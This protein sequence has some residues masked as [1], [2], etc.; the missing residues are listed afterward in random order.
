MKTLNTAEWILLFYR[1]ENDGKCHYMFGINIPIMQIAKGGVNDT[2][3]DA[4]L[5]SVSWNI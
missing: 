1:I 2:F 4:K 5:L 3:N